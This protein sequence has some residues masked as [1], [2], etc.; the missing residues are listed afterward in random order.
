M[1]APKFWQKLFPS[2]QNLRIKLDSLPVMHLV[3]DAIFVKDNF[4][5]L[6]SD[7]FAFVYYKIYIYISYKAVTSKMGIRVIQKIPYL[8]VISYI[9]TFHTI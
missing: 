2:P 6:N 3:I 7:T 8:L 1:Q 5:T 4:F 9:A